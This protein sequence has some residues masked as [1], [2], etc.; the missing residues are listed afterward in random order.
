MEVPLILSKEDNSTYIMLESAISE[1]T[2]IYYGLIAY[3]INKK[4]LILYEHDECPK[5]KNLIPC[6]IKEKINV[7]YDEV[8]GDPIGLQEGKVILYS[9]QYP[10][11]DYECNLCFIRADFEKVRQECLGIKPS[12]RKADADLDELPQQARTT[13]YK[14]IR[15]FLNCETLD[16][17]K[18]LQDA[19]RN[20]NA[21][22]F[23]IKTDKTLK[24]YAESFRSWE[25]K[26]KS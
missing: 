8:S 11:P 2:G 4:K 13:P 19:F 3:L 25:L 12:K 7:Y 5:C 26:Q 22:P 24:K 10:D 18:C 1:K 17:L 23:N 9:E 20:G 16:G 6:D 14:I 21:E 15:A